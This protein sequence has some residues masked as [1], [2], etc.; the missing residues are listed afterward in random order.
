MKKNLIIFLL[1][2]LN[3][4]LQTLNCSAQDAGLPAVGQF[5]PQAGPKFKF[6]SK[7][8]KFEKV[9]AG[10]VLSFDYVFENT[11]VQPLIITNIKVSCGCTKPQ[12]P[13][14]PVKPGEKDTIHV[15]F[16]TSGKI[17][18]QD[19]ILEVHSNTQGSPFK[20]RFKGM[21]DNSTKL[22]KK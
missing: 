14:E 4:K 3:F 18:W 16:N 19:R 5:G 9:R 12:W 6:E 22:Q 8:V 7:S 11:G 15:K 2:T 13:K 10:E 21:V 17:G 20:L 1:L